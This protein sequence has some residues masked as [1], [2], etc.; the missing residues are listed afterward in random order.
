M[1]QGQL[2]HS[3][4]RRG[5]RDVDNR[6]SR[7]HSDSTPFGA[8]HLYGPLRWSA[9]SRSEV[10]KPLRSVV[11]PHMPVRRC[12][13]FG[14]GNQA[15]WGGL[16]RPFAV[17]LC[18]DFERA[19]NKLPS[20]RHLAA[21]LIVASALT[22]V[23][24]PEK[25]SSPF[26]GRWD[27]DINTETGTHANWLSISERDGNLEVWFQPSGG[28]VHPVKQ[29]HLDDSHLTLTVSPAS[30]NQ[31]VMKWELDATGD[32]LTGVQKRG[33][34][35]TPLNGVRAPGLKRTAPSEWTKPEPLFNG[36]NLEGSSVTRTLFPRHGYATPL[37][38][39]IF[40]S[41]VS[42]KYL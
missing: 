13:R 9:K 29:F 37:V 34:R 25:N 5:E 35:S 30:G 36:T 3:A 15:D 33:D 38:E 20:M 14:G 41:I 4:I 39:T 31:P 1:D 22:P 42:N 18:S 26:L 21:V 28:H 11:T 2:H 7:R 19:S 23:A 10:T 27:F 8:L 17:R 24:L 12:P 6:F 16:N 32:K 40:I